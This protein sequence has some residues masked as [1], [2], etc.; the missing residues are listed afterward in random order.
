MLEPTA[1]FRV[2]RVLLHV[3]IEVNRPAQGFLV[4]ARAVIFDQR[5]DDERFA[6]ENFA[7]VEHLSSEIGCPEITAVLPVEEA[8]HQKAV[9]VF[10][11]FEIAV[12]LVAETL[13]MHA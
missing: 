6:V 1:V 11:R 3:V 2:V 12:V 4:T 13:E 10:G 7:I 9:T 5:V 8:L